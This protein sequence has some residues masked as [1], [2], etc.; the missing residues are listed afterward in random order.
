MKLNASK[1][2]LAAG[3]VW[4]LCMFVMTL[5]S[6]QNGYGADFLHLIAG[7][8]PG[9]T[10]TGGGSVIGLIYGFLDAGIGGYIFAWLYNTLNK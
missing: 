7:I 8:Y 2:A 3:I 10:I 1:F 5:I 9:Y 6:V 4:G